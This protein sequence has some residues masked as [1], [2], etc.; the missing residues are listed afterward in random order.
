MSLAVLVY[1]LKSFLS[2][3]LEKESVQRTTVMFFLS[4]KDCVLAV[5]DD[6]T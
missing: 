2:F 1:I 6:A 5:K 4:S 3:V